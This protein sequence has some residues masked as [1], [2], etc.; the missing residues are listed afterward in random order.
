MK[1]YTF[2]KLDIGQDGFYDLFQKTIVTNLNINVYGAIGITT[3]YEGRIDLICKYLYGSSDY[4][5]EL[6][7]LNNIINPWSV[8][9]GDIIFYFRSSGDY[10]PMYET[11]LPPLEQKDSILLMNKNKTTK[12]DPN[13]L[14]S[15]PTI[16]PDNLNQIK[17]NYD[18]KQ[19]TINNIIL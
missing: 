7:T 18:T 2:E 19:I 13:R 12:K 5:E 9:I 16:K 4:T 10:S 3:E 14:G 15:P 8:K 6:M 17:I 1:L 11:D